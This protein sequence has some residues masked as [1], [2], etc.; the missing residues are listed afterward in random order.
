[1]YTIYQKPIIDL[2]FNV[3]I[4]AVFPIKIIA[5]KDFC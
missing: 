3:E 4:L 1:M 5:N 2:T